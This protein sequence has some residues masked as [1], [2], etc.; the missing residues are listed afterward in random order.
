M[1]RLVRLFSAE[2][3][4]HPF[5]RLR[6]ARGRLSC[7]DK[8]NLAARATAPVAVQRDTVQVSP[9]QAPLV[10]TTVPRTAALRP[11]AQPLVSTNARGS[12]RVYRRNSGMTMVGNIEAICKMIDRCIADERAAAMAGSRSVLPTATAA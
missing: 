2:S 9:Q 5:G 6:A 7:R 12:V 10:A 1:S 11:T 4:I 3:A 8:A